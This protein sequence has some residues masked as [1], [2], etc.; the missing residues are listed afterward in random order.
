MN[1]FYKI[2]SDG[3]KWIS[4]ELEIQTPETCNFEPIYE[5]SLDK[6]FCPC[7]DE[8]MVMTSTPGFSEAIMQCTWCDYIYSY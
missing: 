5:E 3:V 7:C 4:C 2:C 1:G 6:T 8:E